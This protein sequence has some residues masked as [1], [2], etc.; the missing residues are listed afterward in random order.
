MGPPP[1]QKF[2]MSPSFAKYLL[3]KN[4]HVRNLLLIARTRAQILVR[5]DD[6]ELVTSASFL[7]LI[8]SELFHKIP[9]GTHFAIY[10]N[11]Q[12]LLLFSEALVIKSASR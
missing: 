11:I 12:D 1:S 4:N 3:F 10:S 8:L 6:M 2:I 9:F 7:S 5:S